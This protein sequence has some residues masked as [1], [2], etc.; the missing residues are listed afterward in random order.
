MRI[1]HIIGWAALGTVL[2]LGACD[3]TTLSQPQNTSTATA[4]P[5]SGY[6]PV[7]GGKVPGQEDA[8]MPKPSKPHV[9]SWKLHETMS[10]REALMSAKEYLSDGQGFSKA[11][12]TQQ[13]DS[14][15][16]EGFSEADAKFAVKHCGA[17]WDA[18]AVM[19][20]RN[21][22]QTE[23]FSRAGLLQQLT[24]SY[25]EGF[26]EAQAEYAVDLVYGH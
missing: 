21:Y 2:A 15:F 3:A 8:P 11:G 25:G 17:N 1:K 10:E 26:T 9:P 5:D 24:S 19:S 18:Q 4:Q 6:T 23:S 14:S 12:L 13:L 7:P 16:G 22:L 20:A